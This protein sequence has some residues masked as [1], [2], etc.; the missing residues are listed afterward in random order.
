MK[1]I[2]GSLTNVTRMKPSINGNSRYWAM[3]GTHY[4]QTAPDSGIAYCL[5]NY[6]NKVV[7]AEIVEFYGKQTIVNI[8]R[9]G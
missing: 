3:V 5:P 7:T 9:K 2:T 4:V 8:D 6:E 1:K